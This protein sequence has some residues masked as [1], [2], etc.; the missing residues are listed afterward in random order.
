MT[1]LTSSLLFLR[2]L[3]LA[4]KLSSK[5]LSIL[6]VTD[7]FDDW[8][9]L[10]RVYFLGGRAHVWIHNYKGNRISL[11]LDEEN[12][13]RAII[14]ARAFNT[15]D[16]YELENDTI[17]I[18]FSNHKESF[19]L[20][21]VMSNRITF[22]YFLELCF[23]SS[24]NADLR[25]LDEG[26]YTVSL[27]G[28]TWIVRKGHQGDVEA[29]PSLT[30]TLEPYEYRTWFLR[31]LP[32]GGVFIDVGAN[33]G[34]YSVRAC[35]LGAEVVS[36]EPDTET[37]SLLQRNIASNKCEKI[38]VLN[39]AAG[40]MEGKMPLYAPDETGYTYSLTRKGSVREYVTVKPLDELVSPLVGD[41]DVQLTKIDVEGAELEV[42]DGA[43][44][45]LSRTGYLMIE[46]WPHNEKQLLESLKKL[47]FK[48]VD[49]GR[50]WSTGTKEV[51]L[52]F[53]RT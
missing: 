48:L 22:D 20:P 17:T 46:L 25:P 42:V 21:E 5:I 37:F 12:V 52:L 10:F 1:P 40:A 24:F 26:H 45:I 2:K 15:W 8:P 44:E 13:N 6:A 18:P 7:V 32:N 53:K 29:G 33:V 31:A 36:L 3:N 39:V 19:K 23:L 14:L 38:H 50:Y 35:K 49:V 28:L 9:A 27:D 34:G 43:V 16:R 51:N 30:R 11:E 4:A 47:N 41:S